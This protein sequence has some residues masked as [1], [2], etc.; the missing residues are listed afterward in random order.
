MDR[1]AHQRSVREKGERVSKEKNKT[2]QQCKNGTKTE[3]ESR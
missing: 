1:S 3:E 2:T